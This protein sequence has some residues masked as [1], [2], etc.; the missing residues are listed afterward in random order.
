MLEGQEM[1][2]I[3]IIK[4]KVIVSL[5]APA[6][7]MLFDKKIKISAVR[8]HFHD[9]HN[10]I[11]LMPNYISFYAKVIRV[12]YGNKNDKTVVYDDL[13]PIYSM[14]VKLKCDN[15]CCA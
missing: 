12:E 5:G 13:L 14:P 1:Q 9:W 8:G 3:S 4:P 11:K 10:G 6:T 15:N 7:C 2:Q